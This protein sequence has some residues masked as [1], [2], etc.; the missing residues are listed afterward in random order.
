[1][2][3]GGAFVS[4]ASAKMSLPDMMVASEAVAEVAVDML[5]EPATAVV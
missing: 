3:E 1:M 4:I 2:F 5:L